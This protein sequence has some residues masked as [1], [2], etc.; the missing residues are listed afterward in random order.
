MTYFC[1]G[2]SLLQGDLLL[3]LLQPSSNRVTYFCGGCSFQ[4]DLLQQLHPSSRWPTL[5]LLQLSRWPIFVAP[6]A[7]LKKMTYLRGCSALITKDKIRHYSICCLLLMRCSIKRWN[8][9]FCTD[10]MTTRATTKIHSYK[11]LFSWEDIVSQRILQLIHL[12]FFNTWW[13]T[14][15]NKMWS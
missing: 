1:G 14:V 3:W 4:G 13:F 6:A 5:W 2:C 11:N 10:E 12:H 8:W 9:V 7:F 15:F